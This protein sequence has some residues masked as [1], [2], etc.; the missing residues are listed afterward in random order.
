MSVSLVRENLRVLEE[1]LFHTIRT[2]DNST[3]GKLAFVLNQNPDNPD[4][5]GEIASMISPIHRNAMASCIF[6]FWYYIAGVTTYLQPVLISDGF[7][8]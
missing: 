2:Q 8:R 3:D 4:L 5:S 1:F 6:E 7:D